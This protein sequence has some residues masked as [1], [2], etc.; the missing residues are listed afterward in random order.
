MDDVRAVLSPKKKNTPR[1]QLASFAGVLISFLLLISLLSYSVGD[2]AT[3]EIRFV[4]L[5]KVF[6]ND[7]VIQA[8]ARQP[9]NVL[10]LLGA[11]ISN[12][13]INSTIGYAVILLPVL[14][15]LWSL[16]LL[17]RR[18]IRPLLIV[19]NYTLILAILFSA[20]CGTI[21]LTGD[22]P[23]LPGEW[24]G[25][26]GDFLASVLVKLIGLF[27]TYVVLVGL[28]AT[29]LIVLFDIDILQSYERLK[30]SFTTSQARAV[31]LS[32]LS[33]VVDTFFLFWAGPTDG[34]IELKESV[35]Q[36]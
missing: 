24:S 30:R 8:K 21:R 36:A 26:G 2:Q 7:E 23:I 25:V 19:T 29:T 33:L 16:A 27:G 1:S 4:D 12:L 13:L 35:A 18:D 34:T 11:L 5:W 10:G 3:G 31:S 28:F 15:L 20:L 14:G 17:R 9:D 32:K 6:T 22:V